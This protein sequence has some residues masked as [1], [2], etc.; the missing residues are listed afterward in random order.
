MVEGGR[1]VDVLDA[2]VGL[3]IEVVDLGHSSEGGWERVVDRGLSVA[4][5]V[6]AG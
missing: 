1:A 6:F 2:G 3:G 5:S 4:S